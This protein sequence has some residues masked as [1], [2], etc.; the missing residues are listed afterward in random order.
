MEELCNSIEFFATFL[1]AEMEPFANWPAV[2][3]SVGCPFLL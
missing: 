3:L 2:R 1:A